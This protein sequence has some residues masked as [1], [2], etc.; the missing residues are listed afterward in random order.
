MA[1]NRELRTGER[2][3]WQGRP[4]RRISLKSFGMY[5][6]AIPWTAFALFWTA[7][8]SLGVG[9]IDEEGG[10]GLLAWAFPLFGVPLS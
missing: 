3:L 1:L 6:F 9:S 8:A 5:A 10:V 4:I 7:M 2:V